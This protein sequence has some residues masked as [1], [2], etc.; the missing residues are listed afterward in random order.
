VFP[1][2]AMLSKLGELKW[3]I[4]SCAPTESCSGIYINLKIWLVLLLPLE[5]KHHTLVHERL[6][7]RPRTQPLGTCPFVKP[8][9]HLILTVARRLLPE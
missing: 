9:G 7:E 4:P 1:N 2:F 8:L 6:R 5:G 3:L